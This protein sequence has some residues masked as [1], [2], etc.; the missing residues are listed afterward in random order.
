MSVRGLKMKNYNSTVSKLG[1]G[2]T[3]DFLGFTFKFVRFSKL[4]QKTQIGLFV[5]VSNR[6]INSLKHE[7]NL[8]LKFISRPVCQVIARLNLIIKK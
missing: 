8:E 1:I 5:Y 7:V 4:T 6:S 3:F 2:Q